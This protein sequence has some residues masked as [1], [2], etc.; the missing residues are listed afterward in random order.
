MLVYNNCMGISH[1]NMIGSSFSF[2]VVAIIILQAVTFQVATPCVDAFQPSVFVPRNEY[3]ILGRGLI[4]NGFISI[5]ERRKWCNTLAG[6]LRNESTNNN[7]HLEMAPPLTQED[8][9]GEGTA[10]D[11]DGDNDESSIIER[12]EDL[13]APTLA[14]IASTSTSGFTAT[15]SSRQLPANWLGE[16][17]Y[18]LF[19][20]ILI[21]LFTGTNIAVFKTAVEFVREVL[22][23][24]GIKLPLLSSMLGNS[25]GEEILTFSLRL[26]EVVPLSAI[27]VLGGLVVGMLLRFGGDMPPGLRDTV[28]EVDL[29]SIRAS[30]ATPP[31]ELIACTNGIP[32]QSERNDFLRFTQKALAATATLGT[33]NSLGPEGPSVEAGMSISRLLMNNKFFSK[34]S[35]VFGTLEDYDMSEVERVNRKMSRDRLLLACGAAAGVSAGFN[36]PLS[37]VFFALEIVQNALVSIDFPVKKE[38]QQD[39]GDNEIQMKTV[40]GEALALQQINISAILLA[41]VVSALT[42]QLL[43]GNELALRLGDFDFNNPL[44]ELPLYLILGAMSGLTAA[45]FSGV[46]QFLKNVIDGEEGPDRVREIFQSIPKYAKPLIGSMVCGIVGKFLSNTDAFSLSICSYSFTQSASAAAW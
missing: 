42:I 43:L 2:S 8:F 34:L 28:K 10:T 7:V 39:G 35:W 44:L 3:H 25:G 26:S 13:P 23:G 32:P 45:I 15:S 18:I 33:G 14:S 30:N 22:Y 6:R 17:T 5:V 46:A 29:D 36:A 27:P 21:G 24:D 12:E 1:C 37:G 41:S 40:G 4:S 11:D 16:K 19:T 20:A 9:I 38:Q 31:M